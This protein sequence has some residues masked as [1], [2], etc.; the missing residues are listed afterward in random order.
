LIAYKTCPIVVENL[1]FELILM[2]TYMFAEEVE[3]SGNN[4]ASP[5]IHTGV[6][7]TGGGTN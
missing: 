3:H 7:E 5:K 6:T 2:Y 1:L 4:F